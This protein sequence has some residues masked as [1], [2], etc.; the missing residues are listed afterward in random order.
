MKC[1]RNV[2]TRPSVLS[3][4]AAAMLAIAGPAHSQEIALSEEDR[5][6]LET[7]N[8]F[9][10]SL[11]TFLP[12]VNR[13]DQ[14]SLPVTFPYRLVQGHI[15]VDVAFG[16]DQ[17]VPF[18]LD[19][20]A[21]TTVAKPIADKHAGDTIVEMG[22]R[23]AGNVL[24]W[25]PL[26]NFPKIRLGD[27]VDVTQVP[28]S[29]GWDAEAFF[30][31]SRNGL[32]GASTMRNAI[33]Q[34]NYGDGTVSIANSV[35]QLDHVD[36]A[37]ALPF[38]HS[39]KSLS[40]SPIVELEIGNGKLTFVVDSGGGIPLTINSGSLAKVGIELPEDA[41][42]SRNLAGGA[43]GSFEAEYKGMT[44][45]AKVGGKELEVTVLV[46]DGMAPSTDG[47]MGHEFLKDYVVTFDWGNKM[48]YLAPL[49][50]SQVEQFGTVSG[51]GYNFMD[52]KILV[53][54]IASGGPAD[55]AGLKLGEVVTAINGA[56]VTRF[57]QAEYCQLV[58][59]DVSTITT[60]S[61]KT[62]DASKIKGFLRTE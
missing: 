24:F 16:D 48:M 51:A 61:G 46:G 47:N 15:V 4:L 49:P 45:P 41:P 1:G 60:E 32:L 19:T 5:T 10:N 44:I 42:T 43:V 36:G 56:D 18:M 50:A 55:I 11:D 62:Y 40:P 28:A 14:D 52:G 53:T 35:D 12:T 33:W 20:G 31:I 22:G 37:I 8:E 9:L 7:L 58:D 23:A 21:P 38:N 26:K 6:K 25:S 2:P 13:L 17:P 59:Y 34:I 57:S 3:A 29:I 54:S 39:P 30:C 27:S